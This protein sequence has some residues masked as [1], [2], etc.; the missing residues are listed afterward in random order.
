MIFS[1]GELSLNKEDILNADSILKIL[2]YYTGIT[3]LPCLINSPFR[4]DKHPSFCIYFV[5]DNVRWKDFSTGE[6]GDLLEFLK[7]LWGL[8]FNEVLS[9]IRRD[10][11]NMSFESMVSKKFKTTKCYRSTD[12]ELLCKTRNW[13]SYDLEYWNSYGISLDW[14]KYADIYPVSDI[15]FVRNGARNAVKADKHAY[16]Y[17][18]FKEGKTTLKIY[19]PFNTKGFKWTNK[20]DMSVISLW[21]KIPLTGEILCICS[22]MKDA[23][24]LWANTGIPSIAVQGEGY[25][26]SNTAQNVLKSRFKRIFILFD[27]DTA[28]LKDGKSLAGKTGFKNIILPEFDGGKDVS[29]LY[30]KI[31]NKNEFKKTILKL[32]ENEIRKTF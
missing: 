7:R 22:S 28:G 30:K 31:N 19:Q 12:T 3:K 10:M 32:F 26:I 13:E 11:T 9:K 1:E 29:D 25:S 15:I 20:H 4:V 5:N 17:A 6:K 18:E 16:A 27:N 2:Y 24:C 8:P 23:L 21:T 14:L